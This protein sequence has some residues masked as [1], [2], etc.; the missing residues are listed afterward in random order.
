[1][2]HFTVDLSGLNALV[3]GA[4]ADLGWHIADALAAAGARL[5]TNDLNPDR[6]AKIATHI[7]TTYGEGQAIKWQ[8]DVSNKLLVGPM[9]EAFRAEIGQ[10]DIVVHAAGVEKH[11]DLFKLDE[12]DW[13]RI[14]DVNINGAFFV[15]QLAAR[16]MSDQGGGVIVNIA[17]TAGHPMPKTGSPGYATSKAATIALTKEMAT[18]FAPDGVRINAL[19]PANIAEEGAP[20]PPAERIPARRWGRPKDVANAT[21]FLCSDAAAFIHGQAI[22]IDGGESML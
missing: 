15:N 7:N 8:A 20:D 17:S 5:M 18:D 16:V 2:N 4:G 22:H 9:I 14:M 3:T 13:R 10:L 11:G 19:C 21:L 6:A 1:M 12:W